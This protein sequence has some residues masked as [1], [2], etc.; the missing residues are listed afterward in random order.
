MNM[1]LPILS[2]FVSLMQYRF[3]S[4][5][6][7]LLKLCGAE[8][9]AVAEISSMSQVCVLLYCFGSFDRSVSSP[10]KP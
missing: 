2:L 8:T 5:F 7:S 10:N 1:H 4:S 6:S 3:G 9:V